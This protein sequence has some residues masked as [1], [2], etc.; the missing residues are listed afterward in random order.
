M[1]SALGYTSTFARLSDLMLRRA[2][3]EPKNR[4][5]YT[6]G[7]YK[8]A[9]LGAKRGDTNA[10]TNL[11]LLRQ[12]DAIS[13]EDEK[14]AIANAGVVYEEMSLFREQ[15]KLP[16]FDNSVPDHI[17]IMVDK[18]RGEIQQMKQYLDRK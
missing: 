5:Q 13:A 4:R 2:R 7:A 3:L 1:A 16:P 11:M 12:F 14:L 8:Y 18:M 9:Y 6:L 17:Q 10:D 15:Q